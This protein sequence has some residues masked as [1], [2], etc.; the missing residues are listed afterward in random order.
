MFFISELNT[1]LLIKLGLT[2]WTV[3]PFNI[4]I[5]P[6]SLKGIFSSIVWIKLIDLFLR[7]SSPQGVYEIFD[8]LCS[9]ENGIIVRFFSLFLVSS[10]K[11]GFSLLISWLSWRN[12]DLQSQ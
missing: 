12:I 1:E 3:P 11:F 5:F 8:K 4:E 2:S 10:L 6:N 9:G 7:L